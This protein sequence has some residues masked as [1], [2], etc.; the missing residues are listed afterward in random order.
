MNRNKGSKADSFF[1]LYFEKINFISYDYRF[2][3]SLFLGKCEVSYKLRLDKKLQIEA[4]LW[5][6]Y[7]NFAWCEDLLYKW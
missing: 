1:L 5:I 4:Q 7:L 2:S 6:L 3:F